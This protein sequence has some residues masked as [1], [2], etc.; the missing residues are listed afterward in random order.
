MR[1]V[2][3]IILSVSASLLLAQETVRL[4]L[5]AGP[6]GRNDTPVFFK[7]PASMNDADLFVLTDIE[8]SYRTYAQR[9]NRDSAVFVLYPPI[10]AGHTHTYELAV[11]KRTPP[12][13]VSLAQDSTSIEIAVQDR[14][15]LRYHTAA[16]DPPDGLPSYYRRSG[17]IHPLYSPEGLVLTDDFPAEH[18]HQHGVFMTWVNTTFR[19]DF[20]DFWNQ[21]DETGTVRHVAVLD[22]VSG[23]VFAR[24]RVKLE[25]LSLKHGPVLGEERTITVFNWYG[26]FL[27]D[28]YS[29]QRPLTGDTL[30]INEYHY[31]G[32]AFRGNAQ[33]NAA[34][35]SA[36]RSDM[37][38]LTSEGI[39]RKDA[40]HTRPRWVAAYGTLREEEAGVAIMG[41]PGNFRFPQ[42]VRVH[43]EMPYFCFAPMVEGAFEIGPSGQY[44][45]K[46]RFF[47][48]TG[49]PPTKLIEEIWRD[50]AEPPAA[51]IEK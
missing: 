23:P 35:S 30:F 15:I 41:H 33:W 45:S 19:G 2:L 18:A 8:T 20:T 16:V 27:I 17:F 14:Q 4:Y 48:F 24:F 39:R 3:L 43:P 51:W 1:I 21:Q 26:H 6:Y 32:L 46:Y 25:H 12:P 5:N 34:D 38:V 31:G 7:I 29:E 11:A 13:L 50:Y 47:V 28:L 42:P 49:T 40:N 44:Q 10:R 9:W 36:Y 37:K 22:T